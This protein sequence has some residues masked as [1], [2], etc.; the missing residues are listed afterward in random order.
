[1]PRD[2]EVSPHWS[3]DQGP[4]VTYWDVVDSGVTVEDSPTDL[5]DAK[6][7][8]SRVEETDEDDDDKSMSAA[9]AASEDDDPPDDAGA[10]QTDSASFEDV[11]AGG[12]DP[13]G[14][15]YYRDRSNTD[16]S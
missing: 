6:Q 2:G 9:P 12:D 13:L 7:V 15:K 11:F 1:L 8:Q 4:D 5:A 10:A 3:A 14:P 16:D